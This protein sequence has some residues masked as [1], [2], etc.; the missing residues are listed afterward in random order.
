LSGLSFWDLYVEKFVS[1]RNSLLVNFNQKFCFIG[2]WESNKL[3]L[4]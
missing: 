4:S 1:V 2:T 3:L